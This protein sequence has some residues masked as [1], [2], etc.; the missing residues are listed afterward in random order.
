[1]LLQNENDWLTAPRAGDVASEA[2]QKF[3][4]THT[5]HAAAVIDVPS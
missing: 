4:V 5:D 1:M 2:A 3:R